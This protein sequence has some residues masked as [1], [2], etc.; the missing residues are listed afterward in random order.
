[1]SST[2]SASS[3]AVKKMRERGSA[4]EKQQESTVYGREPGYFE[5]F[6]AG[7]RCRGSLEQP[8]QRLGH[9]RVLWHPVVPDSW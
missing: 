7:W 3:Q 8:A 4:G 2:V 5:S 6:F 9:G 1:M